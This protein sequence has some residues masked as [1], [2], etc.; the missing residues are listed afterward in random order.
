MKQ[1]PVGYQLDRSPMDDE[2]EATFIFTSNRMEGDVLNLLT[3]EWLACRVA[4][5]MMS[6]NRL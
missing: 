5:W 2:A 4:T 6:Y 1:A 3:D